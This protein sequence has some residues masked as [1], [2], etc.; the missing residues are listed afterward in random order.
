VTITYI[1]VVVLS[2]MMIYGIV[3]ETSLYPWWMVFFLPVIIYLLKTPIVRILKG[4]FRELVNDSYENISLLV[5]FII[6]SLVLWNG[7]VV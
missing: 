7:V 1:P 3:N 2:L 5:F 4:H 6:S